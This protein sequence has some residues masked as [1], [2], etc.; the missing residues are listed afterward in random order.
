MTEIKRYDLV[1]NRIT[2]SPGTSHN[3]NGKVCFY[4]DHAAVVAELNEKMEAA[5]KRI[6]ELEAYARLS[7]QARDGLLER[8]IEAEDE[9][10]RRDAAKGEPVAWQFYDDGN[11]YNGVDNNGHRRHTEKAGYRV[12]DLYPA[13]QPA[14]LPSELDNDSGFVAS[15]RAGYNKAISDAR[16]LGCKSALDTANVKWEVKK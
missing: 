7:Q 16:A 12:R 2:G 1:V 6:A 5:Q 10:A 8:A 4:E 14:T 13:P 3:D 9:L 11:W 15:Y